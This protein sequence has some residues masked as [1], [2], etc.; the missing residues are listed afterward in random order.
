MA[1]FLYWS[2]FGIIILLLFVVPIWLVIRMNNDFESNKRKLVS[3]GIITLIYG[4]ILLLIG[5]SSFITAYQM[6][7]NSQFGPIQG[8]LFGGLILYGSYRISRIGFKVLFYKP[9]SSTK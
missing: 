6:L 3:G 1:M 8:V 2:I 9:D 4:F 5:I 7:G